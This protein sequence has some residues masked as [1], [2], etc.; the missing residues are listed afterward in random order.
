ML[1]LRKVGVA[2]Q[3]DSAESAAAAQID[4]PIEI[5]GRSLVAGTIAAAVKHVQRLVRV[6]QRDQQRMITPFALVTDVHALLALAGGLDDR[7]V[8]VDD[9]YLEKLLWLLA[10]HLEP[11]FVDRL[12]QQKNAPRVES[13]AKVAGRRGIGNPPRAQGVEIDLVGA[14]EFQMFQARAAGQCIVGDVEHM[15]R[16]VVGHVELQQ[17]H[18]PVDRL[19]QT[20]RFDQAMDQS[21]SAGGNG[22][23]SLG[24]LVANVT[25]G[26][27][28]AIA[29]LIIMLIQ[30]PLDPPL[31]SRQS[32][33]Y[34][35]VHSKTLLVLGEWTF[36]YPLNAAARRE[37]SS[38]FMPRRNFP[39]PGSLG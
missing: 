27:H 25:R 12:L 15:I 4:G 24:Q 28:R 10:P 26:E 22:P 6:R 19:V 23:T 16:L 30:P 8:A 17:L 5:G 31:A 3:R 7:A 14:Q 1:G 39:F 9:G 13:P 18:A 29:A 38:F 36:R 37:F 2:T 32:L 21:D 34:R 20:Q 11:R 35:S 33:S